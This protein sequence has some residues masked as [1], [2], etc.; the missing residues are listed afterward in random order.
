MVSEPLE[1]EGV[2]LAGRQTRFDRGVLEFVSSTHHY[3]RG[4]LRKSGTSY[5]DNSSPF[6]VWLRYGAQPLS[7]RVICFGGAHPLYPRPPIAVLFYRRQVV[8]WA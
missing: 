5:D 4:G 6:R 3:R 1:S 7:H 2:C 8:V